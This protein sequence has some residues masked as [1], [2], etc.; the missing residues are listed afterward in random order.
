MVQARTKPD[1]TPQKVLYRALLEQTTG[2]PEL[3]VHWEYVPAEV[4]DYRLDIALTYGGYTVL[5]V[6]VDGYEFH[7]TK[8]QIDRDNHRDRALHR[9]GINLI[10]FSG[11]EAYKPRTAVPE[12][13]A[14]FKAEIKRLP[15]L[16]LD[17]MVLAKALAPEY[18]DETAAMGWAVRDEEERRALAAALASEYDVEGVIEQENG[19]LKWELSS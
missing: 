6:E 2:I 5:G 15:Q 18:A 19:Q 1:L 13:M 3:S 7:H 14:A 16:L 9:A 17:E 4:P 11:R 8:E 12:I 10:R